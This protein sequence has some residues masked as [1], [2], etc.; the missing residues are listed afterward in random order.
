MKH[1]MQEMSPAEL[2]VTYGGITL[3]DVGASLGRAGDAI[4]AA[5][6]KIGEGLSELGE[7]LRNFFGW[8]I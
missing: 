7:L 8:G 6:K 4:I 5:I 2:E 1:N 3:E